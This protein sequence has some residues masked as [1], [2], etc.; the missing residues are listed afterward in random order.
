MAK[1]VHQVTLTQDNRAKLQQI[2]SQGTGKARDI[3][4][5]RILLKA[6][7]RTGLPGRIKRLSKPL[8]SHAP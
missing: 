7:K 8:I 6:D 2:V 3:T 4:R 1:Q 5:A